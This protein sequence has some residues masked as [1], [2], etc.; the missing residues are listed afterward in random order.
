MSETVGRGLGW[1]IGYTVAGFVP[2]AAVSAVQLVTKY[3]ND[4]PL[5]HV[6]K[7]LEMPT[8]ALGAA[9]SLV[10]AR[11]RPRLV[12]LIG[13]TAGLLFS[14]LGD[15]VLDSD[16]R[17]GLLFFLLAHAAYIVMFALAYRGRRPSWWALLAIPWFVG[18]LLLLAPVLGGMLA[19]VAVYGLV[20][21]AMAVMATRGNV[22][23]AVGGLLFVASDTILALRLFT[24]M[25]GG[26]TW[27]FVVM[28]AYL[29]AQTLL[30]AGVGLD[31][32]PATR[33]ARS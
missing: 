23:T 1:R 17:I 24:G 20:L 29:A 30:V 7:A 6:T 10:G 2:F 32:P 27:E 22:L 11:R 9:I 26:D 12:V 21:G 8:L 25:L 28:L 4:L 16:L 13:L 31:T 14:W 5:D 19:L 33:P 18:L 3:S 15:V